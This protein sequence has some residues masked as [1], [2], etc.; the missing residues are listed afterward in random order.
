MNSEP[1]TE[2][3]SKEEFVAVEF[4]DEPQDSSSNSVKESQE[5]TSTIVQD[6]YSDSDNDNELENY[7]DNVKKRINQ[8]TAKRKQALEESEAAYAYA[9]QVQQQNEEMKKRLSDLDKGYVSEYGARVET[10]ESAVKKAMQEAFDAGDME[11]VAEAQ[12]AISQLTIEKERLRIQKQR[13][14][15]A[16]DEPNTQQQIQP[17]Q[18]PREQDLDPKLRNWMSKNTWFG[19]GGDMVMSEGAKAIHTQLVGSE[20]FDPSTDEYYAEVDKR[21]RYHFP[22]K[23][24]E[25][26]QSAQAVAPASSGRSATKNGRKDTVQLNKGQVDFCKKMGIK[27]EDYAREV[28]RLEKR[29]SG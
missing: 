14:E 9:R 13:S 25:Q 19:A 28:A 22:H 23:F 15:Q 20:G 8:L 12:S 16:V 1:Q 4:S 5:E 17:P 6:V 2:N 27:L 7:S 24:Q 10:Q 29:K 21:M 11:K 3:E 18:A 26:R